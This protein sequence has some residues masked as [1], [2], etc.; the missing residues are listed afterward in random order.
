MRSAL[1]TMNATSEAGTSSK[2]L[3]RPCTN[4]Q[5][6]TVPTVGTDYFDEAEPARV[7]IDAES[8]AVRE[9]VVA[10]ELGQPATAGWCP[11]TMPSPTSSYDGARSGR[12]D[13]G[14]HEASSM[15]D[16]AILDPHGTEIIVAN[17]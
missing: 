17:P 11:G 9:P 15:A 7:S 14:A 12:C 10:I 6:R 1:G 2:R 5:H 16:G 4:G 3:P 13:L 8:F